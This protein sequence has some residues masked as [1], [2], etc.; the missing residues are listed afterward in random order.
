MSLCM[1]AALARVGGMD[2][3]MGR[4]GGM[5]CSVTRIGGIS[6]SMARI[7]GMSAKMTKIGRISCAM[8]QVCTTNIRRPYLEISPEVVWLLAGH[9]END[10]YSNTKWIIY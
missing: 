1:N 9:T 5:E 2:A 10:V 6:S 7:G 8:Y 3:T 4:I